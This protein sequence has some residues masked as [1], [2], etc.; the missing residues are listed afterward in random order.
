MA[1][2]LS[3]NKRGKIRSSAAAAAVTGCV[4]MKC[5][6]VES[7]KKYIVF[8]RA[9]RVSRHTSARISFIHFETAPVH[10]VRLRARTRVLH[11]D[12]ETRREG[13]DYYFAAVQTK[14]YWQPSDIFLFLLLSLSFRAHFN[15]PCAHAFGT[16]PGNSD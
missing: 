13:E 14:L 4:F 15:G 2:F 9:P 8:S 16:S 10:N 7:H 11:F 1:V 6:V 3:K 5:A 12:T